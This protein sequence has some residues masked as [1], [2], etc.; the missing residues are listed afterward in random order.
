MI[1]E[2]IIA[3]A[4][5]TRETTTDT[6]H[7]GG[8]DEKDPSEADFHD[9]ILTLAETESGDAPGHDLETGTMM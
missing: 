7:R 6:G 9:F 5:G 2:I 4:R 1:T 3:N 8:G